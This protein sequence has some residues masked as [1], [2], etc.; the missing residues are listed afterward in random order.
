MTGRFSPACIPKVAVAPD[1][2]DAYAAV[3]AVREHPPHALG[4][5]L[6]RDEGLCLYP[7]ESLRSENMGMAVRFPL[8]YKLILGTEVQPA[9]L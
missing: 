4:S 7:S 6:I 3:H 1:I 8:I 2:S 9:F 5:P